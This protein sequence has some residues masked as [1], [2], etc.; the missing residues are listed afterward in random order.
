MNS[1]NNIENDNNIEYDDN[2]IVNADF[3]QQISEQSSKICCNIKCKN[4]EL[5]ENILSK[6]YIKLHSSNLCIT[7][8][9]IYDGYGFGLNDIEFRETIEECA[10]CY[11]KT[12]Q[13][14]FPTNCGHWFCIQCTQNILFFDITRYHLSPVIFGCEVCPNGCKNPDQGKQC[15]CDEY[16]KIKDDWG[17]KYPLQF[18][19]W[20]NAEHALIKFSEPINDG[21]FGSGICPLCRKK[22]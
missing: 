19:E 6:K 13:V 3:L 17:I 16:N 18:N 20:I 11:N 9:S 8:G 5:C 14:K 12:K 15:Y 10:I 1:D 4:Y 21:A 22:V 2:N 7:C